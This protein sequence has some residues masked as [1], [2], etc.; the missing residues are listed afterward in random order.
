MQAIELETD[1]TPDGHIQLPGPLRNV[2]GRHARLIL[3]LE[4]RQPADS[5][6][7]HKASDTESFLAALA[8][9]LSEDFPNDIDETDLGI[10]TPR[11]E[12]D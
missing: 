9:G 6:S 2:F 1:I 5:P 11:R 3:L 4:E 7:F 8:G 10:D 12:L